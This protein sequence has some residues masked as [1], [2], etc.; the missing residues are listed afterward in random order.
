M[1]YSLLW[2]IEILA[3]LKFIL[4]FHFGA[5]KNTVQRAREEAKRIQVLQPHLLRNIVNMPTQRRLHGIQPKYQLCC[6]T[7]RVKHSR[8]RASLSFNGRLIVLLHRIIALFC[9]VRC[10]LKNLSEQLIVL[11]NQEIALLFRS[12][13]CLFR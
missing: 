13:L 9:V 7:V 4:P 1:F 2:L 5:S 11:L 10:E 3:T 6:L 12:F 8:I